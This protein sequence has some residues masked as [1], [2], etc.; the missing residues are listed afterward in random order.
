MLKGV[1][2]TQDAIT[3]RPQI[4]VASHR[5]ILFILRPKWVCVSDQWII[6][7]VVMSV[8]CILLGHGVFYIRLLDKKGHRI[9]IGKGRFAWVK[10]GGG[11]HPFHWL[12]LS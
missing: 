8:L 3:G 9:F 7:H 1:S 11:S 10:L 6:L 5:S 12:D 4:L 2:V